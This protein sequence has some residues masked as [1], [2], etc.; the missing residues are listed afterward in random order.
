MVHWLLSVPPFSE[1]GNIW[2]MKI[3]PAEGMKRR[4]SLKIQQPQH[5][6]T[7]NLFLSAG[8]ASHACQ[9]LPAQA[10]GIRFRRA[11]VG[12]G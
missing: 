1:L 4:A 6:G 2:D 12:K 5:Q 7:A 8:M 9:T 11:C 10:K 3:L